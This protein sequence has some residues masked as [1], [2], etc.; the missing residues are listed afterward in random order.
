M[1][2]AEFLFQITATSGVP[3]YHQ[4]ITQIKT[5]IATGRLPTGTFLPS[6]RQ[7]GKELEVNPM[8]VSK[9]YA[10]LER[11]GVLENVRGQGMM[12][13]D[14][15]RPAKKDHKDRKGQIRPILEQL[16]ANAKQLSLKREDVMTMLEN[17]WKE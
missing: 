4:L 15:V 12:V 5:L 14:A 6:I 9:A 8:T 10:I 16:I 3:I 11:E 7:V 17:L 1:G 2:K 13:A